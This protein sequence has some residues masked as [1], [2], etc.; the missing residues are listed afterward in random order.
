AAMTH[1]EPLVR[2]SVVGALAEIATPSAIQALEKG[3]DDADREVRIASVR[4]VAQHKS[5]SAIPKITAVVTGKSMRQAD[6]TEKMA[7]FEAYGSMVGE[8][9]VGM[10]DGI[11]NSGGFLKKKEDPE[12]RACAAMALGRIGS[13]P[14]RDSLQKAMQ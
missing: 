7:F 9:G 11:L 12:T 1:P 3:L 8:S 13:Q 6:L 14:A 2:A 4:V 10:L 5:R